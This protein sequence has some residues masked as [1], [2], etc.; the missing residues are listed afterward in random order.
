MGHSKHN[1]QKLDNLLSIWIGIVDN[2]PI[3]MTSLG[4]GDAICCIDFALGWTPIFEWYATK[5]GYENDTK[6]T[7]A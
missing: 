1:L 7:C 3:S 5:N 6:K 4:F 2:Q